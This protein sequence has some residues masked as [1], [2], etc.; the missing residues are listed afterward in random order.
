MRNK[1]LGV[2]GLLIIVAL[3]GGIYYGWQ[4]G[5][6]KVVNLVNQ[7][8]A[9]SFMN[10]DV[11]YMDS[12]YKQHGRYVNDDGNWPVL[13]KTSLKNSDSSI[14]YEISFAEHSDILSQDYS[15]YSLIAVSAVAAN[16]PN[17]ENICMSQDG[18]VKYTK[19]SNCD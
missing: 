9:I 1:G 3:V 11:A 18:V 6:Q 5:Y 17:G 16:Q 10:E 13:P 8:Q 4:F 14:V 12:F 2:L 7:R 15:R 19:L